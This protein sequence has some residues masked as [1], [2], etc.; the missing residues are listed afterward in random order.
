[1][2]EKKLK[3]QFK[4]YLLTTCECLQTVTLLDLS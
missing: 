4:M 2:E 3:E 1:M